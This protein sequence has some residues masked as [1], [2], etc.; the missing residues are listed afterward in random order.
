MKLGRLRLHFSHNPFA[1]GKPF[2]QALRTDEGSIEIAAGQDG[3]ELRARLWV[4]ANRP[5][6]RIETESEQAFTLET[7]LEL[8]RKD[9]RTLNLPG[10]GLVPPQRD[11]VLD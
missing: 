9:D 5:V 2:R 3:R 10:P 8:W 6:V 11:V 1:A 4:D 7:R